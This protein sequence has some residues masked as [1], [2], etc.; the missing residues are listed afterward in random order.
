MTNER[1]FPVLTDQDTRER[2]EAALRMPDYL[3]SPDGRRFL[4]RCWSPVIEVGHAVTATVRVNVCLDKD[5]P[6]RD[7]NE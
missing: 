3:A 6:L 4:V 1:Q 5:F 2:K 7:G